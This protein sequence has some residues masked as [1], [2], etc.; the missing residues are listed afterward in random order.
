MKVT[1]TFDNSVEYFDK[2]WTIPSVYREVKKRAIKEGRE[3]TDY[4]ITKSK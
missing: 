1:T 4:L 2:G 3:I